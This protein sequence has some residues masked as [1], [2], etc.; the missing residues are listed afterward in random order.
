[1]ALK[2]YEWNGGTWQFEESEAPEGAVEVKA[3]KPA[4]K[5]RTTKNKS[6]QT[7]TKEV[8]EDVEHD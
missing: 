6:R 5:T 7:K 4:N 1:M 3:K 2:Q 8:E